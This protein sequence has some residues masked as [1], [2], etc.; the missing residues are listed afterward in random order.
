MG[1]TSLTFIPMVS[2]IPW[3]ITIFAVFMCGLLTGYLINPKK[4]VPRFSDPDLGIHCAHENVVTRDG[5]PSEGSLLICGD[6]GS[7]FGNLSR[8]QN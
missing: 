8:L 2:T 6:C 4:A 3:F 1:T 5:L 7:D